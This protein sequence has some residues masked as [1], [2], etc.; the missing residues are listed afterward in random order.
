[1]ASYSL[2]GTFL[3]PIAPERQAPPAGHSAGAHLEWASL[4]GWTVG[5]SYFASEAHGE[6]AWNHLGGVDA[7]WQ[8]TAR[9]E[10]SAEAL[11]GEGTREEG[12]LWGLYAQA[13]IET[14]PTLYAVGRYERFDPPGEGR[15]IDLFDVGLAWVP[16][17]YLRL[18]ADY[19]FADHFDDELATP[20]FRASLS[21]LF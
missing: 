9:L 19:R 13:V 3:D 5:G 20:G 15:A 1:V 10:L 8:P 14:L 18:K 17:N 2:Y 6:G 16:V 4:S 12:A 11:F 21:V 7:L